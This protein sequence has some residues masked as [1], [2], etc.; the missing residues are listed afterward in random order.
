MFNFC[1][2]CTYL[3]VSTVYS[4]IESQLRSQLQSVSP[5]DHLSVCMC[6]QYHVI[7]SSVLSMLNEIDVFVL[8]KRTVWSPCCVNT[9]EQDYVSF[10]SSRA[11]FVLHAVYSGAHAQC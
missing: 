10:F 2:G 5:I 9:C 1:I 6:V 11:G 3:S 8:K 7:F 4:K